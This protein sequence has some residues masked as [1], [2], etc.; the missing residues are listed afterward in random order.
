M[1]G[2]IFGMGNECPPGRVKGWIFWECPTP[3]AIPNVKH[4]ANTLQKF[5]ASALWPAFEIFRIEILPDFF[6]TR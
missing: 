4:L 5:W 2:F 6:I 3:R 1:G